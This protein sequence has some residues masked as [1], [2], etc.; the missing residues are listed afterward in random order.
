[1]QNPISAVNFSDRFSSR[2]FG[3]NSTQKQHTYEYIN[4][5]PSIVD[6][7]GILKL[8]NLNLTKKMQ[9]FSP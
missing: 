9:F 1:L 7:Q 8:T 3:L 6:T 5:S 4:A 2:N